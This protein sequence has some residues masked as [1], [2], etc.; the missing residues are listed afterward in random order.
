MTGAA[1]TSGRDDF[2]ALRDEAD[3]VSAGSWWQ[4]PAAAILFL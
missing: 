4:D 3:G 1:A 2:E